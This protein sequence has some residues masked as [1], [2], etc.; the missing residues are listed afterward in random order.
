MGSFTQGFVVKIWSKL[1]LSHEVKQIFLTTLPS[2]Q[3]DRSSSHS[4]VVAQHAIVTAQHSIAAATMPLL[5]LN[6][7]LQ[8]LQCHCHD[9]TF[10]CSRY[11]AIVI[12]QHAIVTAQ[13]SIAAATMPLQADPM[14]SPLA[15]QLPKAIAPALSKRN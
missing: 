4:I 12:A 1:N 5:W 2:L 6:M 15:F 7:P 10:D 13:H 14:R 8:P 11:N 9:S 3:C